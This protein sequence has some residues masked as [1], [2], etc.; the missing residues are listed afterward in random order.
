MN[1]AFFRSL[2]IFAV[3]VVLAVWLGFLIAGPLTYS[4]LTI[5]AALAFVMILPVL[6]RW[7]Y[8]LMLL[9]WNFA[10]VAIFVPGRPSLGLTMIVLSLGISILQRTM[11][12]HYHFVR[13]PQITVAL[14]ALLL[15]VVVTAR[16]T[17]FGLRIF[18]GDIY[19]GKKYVTLLGGILGYF[20]LS[21]QQIPPERRNLY[22]GLFF[23]G[24]VSAV[25]GDIVG[26]LPRSFYILFWFFSFFNVQQDVGFSAHAVTRLNGFMY[27]SMAI[28]SFML[29]RYGLRG[30]FLSGKPWRWIILGLGVALGL[31]GGYRGLTF[32]LAVT[33]IIQFFLE[34]LYR[35]KLLGIFLS[36]G[37]LGALALIPLASHLPLG[38]QRAISFLPYKVSVEAQLDA[39]ATLDWRLNMWTALLPQIPKYFFLGK[40]YTIDPRDFDFVMG[41]DAA[42]KQTFAQNDPLAL[43]EDFHNGPISVVIPFGIWGVIA[44]LWFVIVALRVLYRNYCYGE[45]DLKLINTFLLAAFA[46][47][48][49]MFLFVG[50]DL[51]TEMMIFTGLLGLSVS[52]NGGVR[53]VVRA[54]APVRQRPDPSRFARLHPRPA[55]AFPRQQPGASR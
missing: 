45:P 19:G 49:I 25:I 44:F 52:F 7:H 8:P 9:C 38:M 11:N 24:G 5:Y 6:L 54:A 21:A 39:Q 47:R 55:P 48:L 22:L 4:S 41:P 17:G 46:G 37:F 51:S 10:A 29:A 18:G 36:L 33:A 1:N 43:A 12:Q 32:I 50:G 42:V 13:V 15:V 16:L 40:G 23:L 53:K 28:F 30:I 27:A 34:K 31:L 35:T 2:I 26:F 14:L 20:A 3:C